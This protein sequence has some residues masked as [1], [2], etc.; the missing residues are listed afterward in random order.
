MNTPTLNLLSAKTIQPLAVCLALSFTA[1]AASADEAASS[2]EIKAAK[3]LEMAGIPDHLA[4][5]TTS[6]VN[7]GTPKFILC[8][9]TDETK[10]GADEINE[11][12]DLIGRHFGASVN[13]DRAIEKMVND[14]SDEQMSEIQA[15]FA[16]PLGQK[17]V[18]AERSS[19]HLSVEEFEAIANEYYDSERWSAMR[20]RL[21]GTVYKATRAARF[22]SILNG[23][24]TI[25]VAVSTHCSANAEGYERLNVKLK[26]ARSDARFAER[27]MS[28]DINSV[29]ATV[30]RDL[31]DAEL[32]EY[33]DFARTDVGQAYFNALLEATRVGIAGGLKGMRTERMASIED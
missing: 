26:S 25:A 7:E 20:K 13:R 17:I 23:E 19:K 8:G 16:K 33:V 22:V 24:I 18:E 21:V 10:P 15:W 27:F 28:D 32:M 5:V 11:F 14:L 1:F 31:T 30:F 2:S 6:I 9:T 3:I 12:E 4:V 29:I